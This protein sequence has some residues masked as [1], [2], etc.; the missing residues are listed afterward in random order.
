MT[1]FLYGRRT[2]R[3][4]PGMTCPYKPASLLLAALVS[5]AACAAWLL[6]GRGI[7]TETGLGRRLAPG[8]PR[9]YKAQR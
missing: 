6:C 5:G 7:P 3:P 4:I 1:A 8:M 9:P 2:R